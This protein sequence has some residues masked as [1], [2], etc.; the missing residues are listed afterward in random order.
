MA[1]QMMPR[2]G[3]VQWNATVGTRWARRPR[4]VAARGR[5]AR[6][7]LIRARPTNRAETDETDPRRRWPQPVMRRS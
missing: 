7:A 1:K 6:M 4:R 3:T 2:P 5:T